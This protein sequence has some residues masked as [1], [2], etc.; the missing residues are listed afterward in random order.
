METKASYIL[1]GAFTLAVVAVAFAYILWVAGSSDDK[2]QSI[3][4]INFQ[5]SVSGLSV[6]APVLLNGVRVGQVSGIRLS[7]TDVS[8]VHVEI[9]VDQG[10]PIRENSVATLEAQGLTGTSRVM[11]SGGT[12]DSP[13]LLPAKKGDPPIIKSETAGL[14]AII[15]TMPQL[16]NTAHNTLQHIDKFF[17]AENSKNV[18]SIL[19]GF[20]GVVS[21]LNDRMG[22]IENTLASL[23][24]SSR[25][26]SALLNDLRPAGKDLSSAM[27]K[28]KD[29]MSRIDEATAAAAPG[30]EKFSRDGV[31]DFRRLMVD[32]RQMVISINRLTQKIENDPR[33][34]LFGQPLPEYSGQ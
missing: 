26:L 32:A 21:R 17:S 18:A 19:A 1:V 28:F 29:T 20:N 13:L 5:G 24:S 4:G 10:T 3:Y 12:N 7:R 8:A 25:E 23:E 34:F 6:T 15:H 22:S 9:S 2:A 33:R 11:I 16:L 14:Q 30:L 27:D 31:D